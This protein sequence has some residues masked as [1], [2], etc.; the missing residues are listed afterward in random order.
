MSTDPL[1]GKKFGSYELVQLL[2][3]GGM[4][5]VYRGFQSSIDRS[6]AVKVLPAELL[7]DPN[8]GT[9]FTNEARTLAKLNHPAILPLYDFG[10][11][12][13]M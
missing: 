13:G 9:R 12:N 10:E 1:L 11:A 6:V 4:A 2:G 7:Y 5:A 3:R 8:F